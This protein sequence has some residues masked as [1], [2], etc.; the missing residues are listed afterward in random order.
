MNIKEEMAIAIAEIGNIKPWFSKEDQMFVF[1]SPVYS[2]VM[3]AGNTVKEAVE[4]YS[5]ALYSFIEYRIKG[6]ICKVVE[7]DTIGTAG[8]QKQKKAS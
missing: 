8:K 1:E 3:G 7:S 6:K 5:R 4:S 2:R